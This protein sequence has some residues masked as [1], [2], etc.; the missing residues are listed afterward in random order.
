[1][2]GAPGDDVQL[3]EVE[4]KT[5]T[6]RFTATCTTLQN[7]APVMFRRHL[8]HHLECALHELDTELSS[9]L[10]PGSAVNTTTDTDP[11]SY[12]VCIHSVQEEGLGQR[13]AA[14][15]E[16]LHVVELTCQLSVTAVY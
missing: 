10:Q 8:S 3:A 7:Y 5:L 11:E 2:N 12:K 15:G 1:L 6:D 13:L 16:V 4:L 14:A 9:M